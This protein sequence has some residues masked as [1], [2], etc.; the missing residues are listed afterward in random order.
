MAA[1]KL[2]TLGEGGL[3]RA[4]STAIPILNARILRPWTLTL[5]LPLLRSA[6]AVQPLAVAQHG[7]QNGDPTKPKWSGRCKP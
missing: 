4:R 5:R 2:D 7:W 6:T 1:S 3:R